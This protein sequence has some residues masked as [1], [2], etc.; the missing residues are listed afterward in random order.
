M[1]CSKKKGIT[2]KMKNYIKIARPDH[3]IKNMF[4]MP[5]II[6]GII[7]LCL[8]QVFVRGAEMEKDV[9]GLV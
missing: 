7:V 5:G 2:K 9:D 3:W 1:N 8:T 6:M 4:I